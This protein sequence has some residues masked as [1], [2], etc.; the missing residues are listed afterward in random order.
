MASTAKQADKI[1]AAIKAHV[2][3]KKEYPKWYAGKTGDLDQRLF[4]VH[5]VKKNDRSTYV[6]RQATSGKQA[7]KAE[8]LL[9]KAGFKGHSGGPNDCE[10]VYAYRITP[11]T[12]EG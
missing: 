10:Y 6:H 5:H 8:N 2:G 3:K 1:V 11:T 9:L 7:S 12:S 4:Q